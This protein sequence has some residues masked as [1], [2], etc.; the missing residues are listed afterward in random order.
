MNVSNHYKLA[1]QDLVDMALL[2]AGALSPL[3]SLLSHGRLI[4]RLGSAVKRML[5]SSKLQVTA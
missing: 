4:S 5:D 3:F 2:K 1:T